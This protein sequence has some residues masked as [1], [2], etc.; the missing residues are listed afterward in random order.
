MRLLILMSV[1][2]GAAMISQAVFFV[3]VV[4]GVFMKEKSFGEVHPYLAALLFAIVIR[5]AS[6]YAI[7]RT[8]VDMAAA[9]K[10]QLR[11]KLVKSFTEDPLLSATDSH[12]GKKVS[13]LL[14]AVDE[15]DGFFSKYIPQFIQI[16]H[17]PF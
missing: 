5:S 16:Y 8:G 10:K 1:L 11:L 13:L 17:I 12:S 2:Q 4:D 14:D 15:T 3:M 9:V 6:S 7:G